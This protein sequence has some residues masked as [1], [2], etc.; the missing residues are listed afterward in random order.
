MVAVGFR[1]HH[2]SPVDLVI[3]HHTVQRSGRVCVCVCLR[4]R[5]CVCARACVL[6]CARA[7]MVVNVCVGV[8]VYAHECSMWVI[9]C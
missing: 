2:R 8:Y 6:A 3:R 1:S 9:V 4:A 7:C 5:V